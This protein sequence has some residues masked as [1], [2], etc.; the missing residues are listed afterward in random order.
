MLKAV[1][2]DFRF[3]LPVLAVVLSACSAVDTKDQS[4]PFYSFPAG[5]TL[6]LHQQLSIGRDQ[7]SVYVQ[8]GEVL[9]EKALDRYKPNCKFEIYTMSE[10]ERTVQPGSF[11]VIKVVDEIETSMLPGQL[12]LA[13]GNFMLGYGVLDKSYIYN[14]ATMMYLHSD[15]Q[16]DVFRMTCQHWEDMM[17]DRYL[18]LAQMRQA[19]GDVFSLQIKE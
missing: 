17:D 15:V 6:V 13:S 19:M 1:V 12:Q 9:A 7:V 3:Y 16:K 8:N 11:E 10:Q 18:T 5:S 14:Y 4:S 2:N